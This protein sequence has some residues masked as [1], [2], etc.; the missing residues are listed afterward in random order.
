M[1][2]IAVR[3]IFPGKQDLVSVVAHAGRYSHVAGTGKTDRIRYR[4]N[5]QLMYD[6]G[7]TCRGCAHQ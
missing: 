6:I 7:V 2:L 5:S 4:P 3:N 1:D